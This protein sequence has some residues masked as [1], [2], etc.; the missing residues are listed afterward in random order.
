[1]LL[2]AQKAQ[3]LT[4]SF[5]KASAATVAIQDGKEAGQSIEQVH[6]VSK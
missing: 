3:K 5:Y 1:M 4:Q 2:Q 6:S